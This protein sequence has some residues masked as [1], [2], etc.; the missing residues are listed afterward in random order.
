M[1]TRGLPARLLVGLAGVTA[2]AVAGIG[3]LALRPP[4]LLAVGLA[5][6]VTACLAGGVARESLA[7]AGGQ[8]R[9]TPLEAAWRTG[10]A[11]VGVLLF[12]SGTAV[13][14][15]AAL[16]ALAG[17]VLAVGALGLW[18][19]RAG[20]PARPVG[21]DDLPAG[22]RLTAPGPQRPVAGVR[23]GEPG[24]TVTFLPPVSTLTT[25]ALGRE[26][27]G[28]TAALAG[29]LDPAARQSIV[30]RRQ[31]TLDELE[32]RD[33]AGFARWLAEGPLPGSD[34]AGYLAEGPA[35]AGP[36]AA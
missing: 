14:G 28:T 24:N 25:A 21:P 11:T 12:L 29:R 5:A 36:D 9:R 23:P 26:W 20:S 15:G 30:R 22:G 18:L 35:A 19:L 7:E 13:L 34:P 1:S 27:L 31:D 8:A 2:I 32:R 3:G 10:A 33:P 4:G 6:V 16:T 17:A